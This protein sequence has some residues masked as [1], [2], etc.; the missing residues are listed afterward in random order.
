MKKS[1]LILL[2]AFALPFLAFSEKIFESQQRESDGYKWILVDDNTQ[3][4]ARNIDGT[5]FIPIKHS[6]LFYSSGYFLGKTPQGKVL[7]DINGKLL[8]GEDRGY[9]NISVHV[10]TNVVWFSVI[11]DGFEGVCDVN[12]NEILSPSRGFKE[13][14]VMDETDGYNWIAVTKNGKNGAYSYQGKEIIPPSFNNLIYLDGKFHTKI[15]SKWEEANLALLNKT[16]TQ[17]KIPPKTTSPKAATQTRKSTGSRL[18]ADDAF[19]YAGLTYRQKDYP[20]ALKYFKMASEKGSNEAAYIVGYMYEKGEGVAINYSEAGKWY[21]LAAKQGNT[22]ALYSLGYLYYNGRG[23]SKSEVEAR[24][25]WE[26]AA[27]KGHK[28]AQF[29]TGLCYY[30]GRGV[31]KDK[32]VGIDWIMKARKQGDKNAAEFVDKLTEIFFDSL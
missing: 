20:E 29:Q 5:L 2:L 23:V 17:G 26:E 21:R 12:G 9:D 14:S 19:V 6:T 10:R 15:G 18:T 8:I 32:E 25:F 24:K 22:D 11:K 7:Y 4:G 13:A 31:E 30:Y 16:N 3:K 28:G 1:I 27:S